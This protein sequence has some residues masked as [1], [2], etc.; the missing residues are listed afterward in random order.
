MRLEK[1]GR[2]L[3]AF[4]DFRPV[5]LVHGDLRPR[6]GI[7]IRVTPDGGYQI[8]RSDG[9]LFAESPTVQ[10]FADI[11]HATFPPQPQ[12]P[13]SAPPPARAPDATRTPCVASVLRW[14]PRLP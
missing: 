4:A 11:R 5:V 2:E 8:R 14:S 1:L 12:L 7:E 10:Q 6:F 9:G 13:A 3:V